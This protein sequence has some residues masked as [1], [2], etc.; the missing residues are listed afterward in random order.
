M[1]VDEERGIVWGQ[2][3]RFG[4]WSIKNDDEFELKNDHHSNGILDFYSLRWFKYQISQVEFKYQI[5]QVEFKNTSH[6]AG[7]LTQQVAGSVDHSPLVQKK[8]IHFEIHRRLCRKV[9]EE[10]TATETK[11]HTPETWYPSCKC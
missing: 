9:F 1:I 5:S 2:T 3:S 7:P 8:T 10:L 11:C 6:T 4:D